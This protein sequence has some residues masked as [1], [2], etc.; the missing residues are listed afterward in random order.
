MLMGGGKAGDG[1]GGKTEDVGGPVLAAK[2]SVEALELGVRGEQ[3]GWRR[4]EAD[5]GA[6]AI[7]EA[8]QGW[9][10]ECCLRTTW[11]VDGDHRWQSRTE[12]PRLLGV[13][14]IAD[15]F[16]LRFG[17]SGWR[18]FRAEDGLVERGVV[19]AKRQLLGATVAI[20]GAN[21]ALH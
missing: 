5:E 18:G 13:N 7:E 12:E 15:A 16:L 14:G 9:P 20:V 3:D 4:G 21:D 19:D 6:G 8:R 10:E 17:E 11:R 2:G 1:I